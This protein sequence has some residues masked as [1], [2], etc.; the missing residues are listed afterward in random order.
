MNVCMF[1]SPCVQLEKNQCLSVP[2]NITTPSHTYIH[3]YIQ[4]IDHKRLNHERDKKQTVL[5]CK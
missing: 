4:I 1:K 5:I 3:A 2:Y